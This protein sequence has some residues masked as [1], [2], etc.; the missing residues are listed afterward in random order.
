VR[1]ATKPISPDALK[2]RGITVDTAAFNAAMAND[3]EAVILR[4]LEE[5][6]VPVGVIIRI[7]T[8]DNFWAAQRSNW[9]VLAC[10]I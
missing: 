1:C 5:G 9:L 8:S 10:D 6:M 2:P 7:A 3:L 4:L